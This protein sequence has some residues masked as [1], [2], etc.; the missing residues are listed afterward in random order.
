MW[1]KRKRVGSVKA[2]L[3]KGEIEKL[4]ERLMTTQSMLML[5]NNMYLV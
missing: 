4:R 5:A 2:V 1:S 3:K